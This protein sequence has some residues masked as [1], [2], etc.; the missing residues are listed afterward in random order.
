MQMQ[1]ANGNP[2]HTF[3]HMAAAAAAADVAFSTALNLLCKSA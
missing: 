3:Y 1:I 2:L